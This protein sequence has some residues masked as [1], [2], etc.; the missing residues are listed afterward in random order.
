M[1][2]PFE[3]ILKALL[4]ECYSKRNFIFSTFVVISL[5][6]LAVGTIWPKKYTAFT[7]V[8]IDETNMFAW[9]SLALHEASVQSVNTFVNENPGIMN[10][11]PYGKGW[12]LKIKPGRV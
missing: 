8:Q 12:I 7:I 4:A 10:E 2:L 9:S 6:L 5:S 3:D 1:Q 11:D